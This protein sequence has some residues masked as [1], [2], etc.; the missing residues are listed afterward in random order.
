M[1]W[2]LILTLAGIV[3]INRYFFLDPRVPVRL[4]AFI[5]EALKYSAPCLLIAICGPIIMMENG[6]TRS[7]PDNPY[8][9]GAVLT[10]IISRLVGNLFLAVLASLT[11]FYILN[12]MLSPS[13]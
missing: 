1:I 9:W 13:G 4:P 12:A 7:M 2:L 10:V 11:A 3:F 8:L 6:L 5:H